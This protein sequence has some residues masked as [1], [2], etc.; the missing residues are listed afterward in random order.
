M[1]NANFF[2]ANVLICGVFV[3]IKEPRLTYYHQP[4]S[5][6]EFLC[7][8]VGDTVFGRC[9]QMTTPPQREP[10]T[11]QNADT[12]KIQLG[13]PM[14]LLQ[15]TYRNVSDGLCTGREITQRQLHHKSLSQLGCQPTKSVQFAGRS[16]GWQ[17][18]FSGSS[19]CFFLFQSA[20]WSYEVSGV[21]SA[22]GIG[23]L[24]EVGQGKF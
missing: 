21:H 7:T 5:L 11:N 18:S 2:L 19:A 23:P 24:G 1:P 15:V 10:I 13:E 20:L 22:T 4:Y 16:T 14:R 17:I 12:T 9:K 6:F 3:T 8:V